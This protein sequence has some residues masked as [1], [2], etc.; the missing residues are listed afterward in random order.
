MAR[1]YKELQDKMDPASRADNVRAVREELQRMSL[2][3]LRNAK[4]LTQAYLAEM[5][6]TPQ[7]SISR[8]EQRA[9]MYLST[10][11][12]HVH[13]MGGVLQIQAVFL[14]GG[15]VAIN[16]FGD[17]EDRAFVVRARAE[18][19]GTYRLDAEP[20]DRLSDQG[21]PL[22]RTALKAKAFTNTLIALHIPE[23][24]ISNIRNTLNE[25]QSTEIGGRLARR[26]FSEPDLIA[27]GFERTGAEQADH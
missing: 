26:V 19:N 15:T 2:D 1:N 13:A 6:D 4:R 24:Q 23:A 5:L 25:G 3:E 16:R 14:D 7:S 20:L 27:A 10:L 17:Y 8:I 11:R 12:N 21:Q 18:S 22:F 9:D